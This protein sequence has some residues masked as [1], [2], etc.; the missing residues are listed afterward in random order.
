LTILGLIQTD[1]D[2]FKEGIE[3]WNAALNCSGVRFVDF[4]TQHFTDYNAAPPDTPC[5]GREN[6]PLAC[7]IS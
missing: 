2:F 3:K 4:S 5:I 6:L 7:S 1:R